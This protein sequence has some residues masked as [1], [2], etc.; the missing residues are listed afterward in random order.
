MYIYNFCIN[1]IKCLCILQYTI[2][3]KKKKKKLIH[4]TIHILT[5]MG[6]WLASSLRFIAFAC[7]KNKRAFEKPFKK[8]YKI[9]PKKLIKIFLQTYQLAQLSPEHSS[10]TPY[11][12]LLSSP[13]SLNWR[14]VIIYKYFLSDFP[15]HYTG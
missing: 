15:M 2:Q 5:T 4:D 10:Y 11:P 3:K 6:G 7:S 13:T 12:P 9:L 1:L 14:E 8:I